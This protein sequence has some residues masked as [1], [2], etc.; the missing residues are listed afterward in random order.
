MM[1]RVVPLLLVVALLQACQSLPEMRGANFV[2]SPGVSWDGA[3]ATASMTQLREIGA[4][5][6]VFVPFL[7]QSSPSTCDLDA[8]SSSSTESLGRAIAVARRLGFKVAVKP[9]ILVPGAWAG[10]VES[11]GEA[12][13][14]CWFSAYQKSL[15]DYAI[16]ARSSGVDM[17]VIGTELKRTEK[18]PEW[19]ALIAAIRSVYSGPLSYVF[20]ESDDAKGFSALTAID[21]VGVSV[22]LPVGHSSTKFAEKIR[23]HCE[24]LKA[25]LR[26]LG[27]PIWIGELG[28]P[29]RF[30]S[31]DSPW[32]WDE[33]V[34][35]HRQVDLATQ[36]ILLD[37]WLDNLNEDWNKGVVIWNWMSDPK[38][39]GP[40]NTDFTPQ[41]KPAES[42]IACRWKGVRCRQ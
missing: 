12:A 32:E 40:M 15:L 16:L 39:G 26:T 2:Q 24:N 21:R 36:A 3:E 4:N 8:T 35:R 28:Y 5:W 22:Y 38:A 33:R 1:R 25:S 11:Y 19:I 41:N 20:H 10:A 37:M 9:Q 23:D 7:K 6:I 31:G 18:R 13:W 27:K 42:A 17:L 14:A 30:G 34:A 29:S